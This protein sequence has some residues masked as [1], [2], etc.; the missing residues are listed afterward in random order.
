MSHSLHEKNIIIDGLQYSRWSREV[1]QMM[2]DG[3]ITAVHVTVTYWEN[4][5]ET[6]RNLGQWNQWFQRHS[7]LIMPVKT[8][9]DIHKAKSTGKVGIIFGF[10]NCSPI[11]DDYTM[12]ELFQQLGVRFMQ[13]TYNNQTFLA[14][15]CYEEVDSGISRFGKVVIQEM[16]RVGMIIDMSHSGERSTLEAIELSTKPI[17]VSHAN[18]TFFHSALRNKSD[19]VLKAL[20]ETGGMLGFSLYPLH[21]KEGSDCTIDSF[22]TMVAQTA[23]LM[24]IDH[25]GIGTD[26]C[27]NQPTSIL[28]WMRNGRWAKETDYGEGSA[29]A[30][31]WPAQPIWIRN[32]ADFG[33]ITQGLID[34]GFSEEEVLKI[35]GGNWL[36]FFEETW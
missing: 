11:E 20:A 35:M 5:I 36:R 34:I 9:D 30:P 16:N 19:T 25:I 4:T 7:D 18:P 22:C 13:L 14:S 27:T 24:G 31:A 6:L 12:V 32:Q 21:L 10:Q 2:Q 28:H 15:G 17:T 23:E 1:F 33:N 3:G 29:A 26:F 8:I